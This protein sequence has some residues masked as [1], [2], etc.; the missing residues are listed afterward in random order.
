MKEV[1]IVNKVIDKKIAEIRAATEEEC[2]TCPLNT[3]CTT[4]LS[5]T[6]NDT[7][8]AWNPV[9]AEKG[10]LVEFEYEERDIVK[11]IF[12]IYMVPFFFLVLGLIVGAILEKG[13]GIK[14]G[15]L[16]NLLTVLTTLLFLIIGILYVREKD[17][18]FKIPSTI[19]YVIVK[20][21]YF[22]N[23]N[24]DFNVNPPKNRIS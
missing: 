11:G 22:A 24:V 6:K 19:T 23:V 5:G 18:K 15:H 20:A 1:G 8:L 3:T 2:A 14:I 17:K 16:E 12:S 9:G 13:L 4:H 7:I 10:D 21:S